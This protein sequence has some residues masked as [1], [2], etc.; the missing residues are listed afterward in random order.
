MFVP[1]K[2]G[3]DYLAHLDSPTRGLTYALLFGVRAG[4]VFQTGGY[5]STKDDEE[6]RDLSG[7]E[8]D[9]SGAQYRLVL[10]ITLF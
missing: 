3:Y 7:P 1:V 9:M 8:P 6:K 4:Y 2:F 10:G 5:W